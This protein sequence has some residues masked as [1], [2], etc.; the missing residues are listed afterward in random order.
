[1]SWEDKF[2]EDAEKMF[3]IPR[4]HLR[5]FVEYMATNPEKVQEWAEAVN[6]SEID[7]LMLTTVYTLYKTEEKVL[8]LLT[9]LD[10]RVDEAIGLISTLAANLLNSL[11]Q[12]DRRPIL[13]QVLLATALQVEDPA[14]RNSLAE[15]AKTILTE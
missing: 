7:F 5:K 13:A 2:L 12:D 10:V 4:E 14:I 1:M 15:Y 9:D 3:Q 6:M 8:N 11:P